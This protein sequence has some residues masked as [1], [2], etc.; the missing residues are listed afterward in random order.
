[1]R[2]RL[3]VD[4]RRSS[5]LMLLL[6]LLV[7]AIR[8]LFL[9]VQFLQPRG[10]LVD[11]RLALSRLLLLFFEEFF[12]SLV[13][14]FLAP[15]ALARFGFGLLFEMAGFLVEFPLRA[16]VCGWW[17]WLLLLLLLLLWMWMWV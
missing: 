10:L 11:A 16:R 8:R 1:M 2:S 3:D 9:A 6:L 15:T 12:G 17:W 14:F 7:L 4:R 5:V 13:G